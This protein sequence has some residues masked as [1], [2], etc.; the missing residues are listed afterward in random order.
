MIALI[1]SLIKNTYILQGKKTIQLTLH[2][3]V[4]NDFQRLSNECLLFVFS[5]ASLRINI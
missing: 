2:P 4:I 1:I 3:A 5:P